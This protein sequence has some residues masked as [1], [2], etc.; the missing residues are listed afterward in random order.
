M[1]LRDQQQIPDIEKRT[2]RGANIVPI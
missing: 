1:E 2:K